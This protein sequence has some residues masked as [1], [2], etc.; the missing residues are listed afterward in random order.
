MTWK[1]YRILITIRVA[2]TIGATS[3]G[4]R[5]ERYLVFVLVWSTFI[6]DPVARWIWNPAGWASIMGALDFAGGTPVH[7]VSGS[8]ALAY[9]FMLDKRRDYENRGVNDQP[10]DAT[11][12][13]LGTVC[14]WVGSFGFSVGSALSANLRVGMAGVVTNIAAGVGGLAWGLLEYRLER[15]WSSVG[16][17]S[18]VISGL[19]VISPGSGYVPVWSAFIFGVVGAVSCSYATKLKEVM[20]IDD[21]TDVFAVHTIGGFVGNILTGVF[22]S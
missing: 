1:L 10:A 22:A 4:V 2:L 11:L 12:V 20:R 18:G 14:Q 3:E 13:I 17:C 6:Y 5:V 16:I 15:K 9:A 19:V 21:P 8:T 7:I